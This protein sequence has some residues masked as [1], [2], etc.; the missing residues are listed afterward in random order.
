MLICNDPKGDSV[1]SS[2]DLVALYGCQDSDYYFLNI[3]CAGPLEE[4]Y[5]LQILIDLDSDNQ[6]DMPLSIFYDGYLW[7]ATLGEENMDWST[8]RGVPD[9]AENH[10]KSSFEVRIPKNFVNEVSV[11]RVYINIYDIEK[12][13]N[14]DNIPFSIIK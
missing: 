2:A 8:L 13:I 7:K 3:R 1:S 4:R 12:S 9:I 5:A 11:I 14:V 6:P 10:N